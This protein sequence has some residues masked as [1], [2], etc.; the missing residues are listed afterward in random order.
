[1]KT[2]IFVLSA[3]CLFSLNSFSQKIM[4]KNIPGTTWI[5]YDS[6]TS[7][8]TTYKF[9]NASHVSISVS[10]QQMAR[11]NTLSYTLDT[12]NNLGLLHIS[13]EAINQYWSVE[14]TLDN[15]LEMQVNLSNKI[16]A[17]WDDNK[18]SSIF[19][20]SKGN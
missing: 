10:N 17:V 1:M 11:V 12:L 13:G 5:S 14:I 20:K 2:L 15:R 6:T 18:S 16:P 3:S 8:T 19:I 9:T 7:K 4:F